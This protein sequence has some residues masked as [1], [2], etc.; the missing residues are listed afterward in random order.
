MLEIGLTVLVWMSVLALS[1]WFGLLVVGVVVSFLNRN[2]TPDV[3]G[4]TLDPLTQLNGRVRTLREKVEFL[5][6]TWLEDTAELLESLDGKAAQLIETSKADTEKL[7]G[8]IGRLDT[9]EG[10]VMALDDR[11]AQ[12]DR[13]L[14]D[15]EGRVLVTEK[16]LELDDDFDSDLDDDDDDWDDEE[17]LDDD[18]SWIDDDDDDDWDSE[19]EEEEDEA[20]DVPYLNVPTV[21]PGVIWTPAETFP[22]P[23]PENLPITMTPYD[24]GAYLKSR[25]EGIKRGPGPLPEKKCLGSEPVGDDQ[26]HPQPKVRTS[27]GEPS[28]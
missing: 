26:P 14:G 28:E 4:G 10:T 24:Y 20:F 16:E 5:E 12:T 13:A 15:L 8:I 7:Q 19:L 11:T 1:S 6:Q 22:L 27:N 21:Q 9:L 25:E 23:V 18:D 3:D 17:D 2:Q